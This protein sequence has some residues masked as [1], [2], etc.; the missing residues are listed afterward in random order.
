MTIGMD[1]TGYTEE[2]S[3]DEQALEIANDSHKRLICFPLGQLRKRGNR[4]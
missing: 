2:E 1:Y 3:R 4:M